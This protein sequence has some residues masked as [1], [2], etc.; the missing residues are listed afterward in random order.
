MWEDSSTHAWTEK[1]ELADLVAGKVHTDLGIA[2][3]GSS[4]SY[5]EGG[6]ENDGKDHAIVS[7]P[8]KLEKRQIHKQKQRANF[9]AKLESYEDLEARMGH[10]LSLVRGHFD[11]DPCRAMTGAEWE[12]IAEDSAKKA[13]DAREL[14]TPSEEERGGRAES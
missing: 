4:R 13:T 10:M 3:E 12:A 1:E 6:M 5:A 14:V 8:H 7:K 11:E 9:S 2:D